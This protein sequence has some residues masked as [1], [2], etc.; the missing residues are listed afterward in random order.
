[1]KFM[2]E[3]T[4]KT[5]GLKMYQQITCKTQ[6]IKVCR[7]IVL[8]NLREYLHNPLKQKKRIFMWSCSVELFAADIFTNDCSLITTHCELVRQC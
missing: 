8:L 4:I 2:S 7:K 1:M 6:I 3:T 5:Q